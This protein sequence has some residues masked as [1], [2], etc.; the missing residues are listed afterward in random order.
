M[1]EAWERVDEEELITEEE[2]SV[3]SLENVTVN[4]ET[5]NS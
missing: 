3:A 5:G 1:V 2:L 4:A